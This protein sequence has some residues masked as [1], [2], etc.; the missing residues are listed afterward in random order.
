MCKRTFQQSAKKNSIDTSN[1]MDSSAI[2]E[3]LKIQLEE[4]LK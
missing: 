1:A 4:K 3:H 2:S